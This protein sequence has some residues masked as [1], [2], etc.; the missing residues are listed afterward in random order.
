MC[1]PAAA[2]RSSSSRARSFPASRRYRMSDTAI[3]SIS[4]REVLDSRGDPTL[5]V[6]LALRGGAAATAMVPSGASTGAHEAV[7]L[8]DHDPRRYGGK[9]VRN[10]VRNVERTIAPE[11]T[12][13]DAADQRAIDDLLR[14]L[15]GTPNKSKL[16]ANAILGVSLACARGRA[17]EGTPALPVPGR[18]RADA[19]GPAH[20]HPERRQA[21]HG[22]RGLPGV[23]D[24]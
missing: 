4:A 16:G 19:A 1:R 9:G 23:H 10:A 17:G 6:D 21:R 24:R 20:E 7:E 2:R 11:L 15:D 5:A 22:L 18:R 3:E 14:G 13:H 12:G 8:R